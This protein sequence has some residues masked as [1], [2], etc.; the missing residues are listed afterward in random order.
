[1]KEGLTSYTDIDNKNTLI[2]QPCNIT[3]IK[4]CWRNE[5]LEIRHFI[6]N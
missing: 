6:T 4:N 1:M 3:S 5:L 2:W